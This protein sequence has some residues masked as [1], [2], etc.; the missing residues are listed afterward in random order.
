MS[1]ATAPALDAPELPMS[2]YRALREG[3]DVAKPAI[4]GVKEPEPKPAAQPPAAPGESGADSGTANEEEQDE[5]TSDDGKQPD[6]QQQDDK[7]PGSKPKGLVDEVIKL[8]RENR[9]LKSRV[10]PPP[11]EQPKP[12][13]APAEAAR[14][15]ATPEAAADVEPDINKYTDYSQYQRDLVRWEIRQSQRQAA[16]EAQRREAETAQ[17]QKAATWQT[18][19]SAAAA[20]PELA[21]FEAIAFNTTLQVTPVMGDAITDSEL[22]PEILYHLGLNPAEAERISKL[23]PVS[24]V[25]EIGKLEASLAK[26]AHAD[27][28]A[29]SDEDPAPQ[30]SAISKAPPPI[31]RPAGS[32][33][34]PNPAKNIEGMSQAEYRALR[35]A[36]RL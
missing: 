17:R 35:E 33:S 21:N 24:Q 34:K 10:T 23:S 26:P 20:K 36:G 3:R 6:Q 28:G 13:G 22:G 4:E 30:K 27:T 9:E 1:E 31:P 25:R 18:R 11:Q 15:A 7:K 8:R 29:A 16:A 19:V 5:S 14:A 32:A 2:D 12:A